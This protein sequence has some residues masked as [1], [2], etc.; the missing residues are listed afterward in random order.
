MTEKARIIVCDDEEPMRDLLEELLTDDGYSVTTAK[1]GAEL[2]RL[3]PQ[4]RPDLVIC[5]LKMPGED[6]LSLTPL[7]ARRK[8]C[9]RHHA[10]RHG[11][12]AGPGCRP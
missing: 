8:P 11:Q 1:D 4:L 6:G 7:A 2:R 12:C 10:D 9:R 5:D 3:V